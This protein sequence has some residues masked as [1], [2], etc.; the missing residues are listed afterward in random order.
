MS[1][2]KVELFSIPKKGESVQNNG[3]ETDTEGVP[4][5][6]ALASLCSATLIF[7]ISIYTLPKVFVSYHQYP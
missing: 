4:P 7:C 5:E 6:E 1:L 3:G 2:G